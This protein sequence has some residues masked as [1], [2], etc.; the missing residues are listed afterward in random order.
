MRLVFCNYMK[1]SIAESKLKIKKTSLTEIFYSFYKQK[2]SLKKNCCND[3]FVFVLDIL[4][5]VF[6]L[7]K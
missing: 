3:I 4:K 5:R 7:C 2:Y 1:K 6:I